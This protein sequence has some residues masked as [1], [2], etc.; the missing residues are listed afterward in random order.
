MKI[1][2]NKNIH[3]TTCEIKLTGEHNGRVRTNSEELMDDWM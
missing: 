1:K 3:A 2:N